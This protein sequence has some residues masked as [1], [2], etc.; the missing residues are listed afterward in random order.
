ML[1]SSTM[2]RIL[3]NITIGFALALVCF[4]FFLRFTPLVVLLAI[5]VAFFSGIYS[6]LD[7]NRPSMERA[8]MTYLTFVSVMYLFAG[9]SGLSENAEFFTIAWSDFLTVPPFA[10]FHSFVRC[11]VHYPCS[12]YDFRFPFHNSLDSLEGHHAL[13]IVEVVLSLVG[14]LGIF[15]ISKRIRVGYLVWLGLVVLSIAAALL[16]ILGESLSADS[17]GPAGRASGLAYASAAWSATYAIAYGLLRK[18][19]TT[20]GP[21]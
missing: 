7:V 5:N 12:I 18:V 21:A 9:F 6:V 10:L 1:Q 15:S 16:T 3:R 4:S 2:I 14:I 19:Q 11:T 8:A 13:S 17:F 20:K